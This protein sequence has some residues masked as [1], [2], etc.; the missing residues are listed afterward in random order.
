VAALVDLGFL[1]MNRKEKAIFAGILQHLDTVA[2]T[3]DFFVSSVNEFGKGDAAAAEDLAKSVFQGE[4]AADTIHRDLS[5]K[6]AQGAFFGGVREDILNLL[7]KIDDIADSAK[8]AARFFNSDTGL[9]ES[10]RTLLGSENM[11]L[12]LND[13]KSTVA[14]LTELVR[15]FEKGKTEVLLKVHNVEEF[16]EFAD[17]RKDVLLKQLFANTKGMDPVTVIQLRDFIFVADNIAD[18]AEDAGDV[19]II[20]IAKGYG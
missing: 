14:A 2:R 11:Q 20:L 18:N 12:F 17:T 16:E 15:A 10:A 9:G 6:V 7:E 13:L 3:V 4:T 8:D 19:I 5:L 1:S